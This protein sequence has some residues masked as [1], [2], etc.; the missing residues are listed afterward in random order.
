LNIHD[1]CL[2]AQAA[3][4]KDLYGNRQ[5]NQGER[6]VFQDGIWVT[7][8][9]EV[10]A[11]LS[12]VCRRDGSTSA[13]VMVQD[14]VGIYVAHPDV[15]ARENDD[16]SMDFFIDPWVEKGKFNRMSNAKL[17]SALL[18]HM[19]FDIALSL[20]QQQLLAKYDFEKTN[21]GT[22]KDTCC[23]SGKGATPQ[24]ATAEVLETIRQ[25][26]T[27][28][29][30]N[31]AFASSANTPLFDVADD[32]A[33]SAVID[34]VLRIVLTSTT[35]L[36]DAVC[37]ALSE[38]DERPSLFLVNPAAFVMEVARLNPSTLSIST[39]LERS[40]AVSVLG[41]AWTLPAGVDHS[42]SIAAANTDPAVW[43]QGA[44]E[45]DVSHDYSNLVSWNGLATPASS[46]P[47][48][49]M[50]VRIA[51]RCGHAY[52]SKQIGARR[53]SVF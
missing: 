25:A 24:Q 8:H 29:A 35:H 11:L 31:M 13:E 52:V 14:W 23:A 34:A 3:T 39:V 45:F 49:A 10:T 1:Q 36:V 22:P 9:A 28:G 18:S 51:V 2:A 33:A 16:L 12:V 20:P 7:G 15:V 47:V 26:E 30:L 42:A 43:G 46:C 6:F 50:A 17:V 5:A 48:A 4:E 32:V 37:S 44:S 21:D 27:L 19:F 41:K 53:G 38:G 40:T